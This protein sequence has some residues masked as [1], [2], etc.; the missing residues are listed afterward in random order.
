MHTSGNPKMKL[1][2]AVVVTFVVVVSHVEMSQASPAWGTPPGE[3]SLREE[4]PTTD[5]MR[6]V[7]EEDLR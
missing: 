3:P 1:A 7:S 2:L 6:A 4:A 5:I